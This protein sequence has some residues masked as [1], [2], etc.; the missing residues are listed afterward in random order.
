MDNF[1]R[2]LT[3]DIDGLVFQPPDPYTAGRFNDL[4]KWKPPE[5]S[6]VDFKLCITKVM[7]KGCPPVHVGFLYV[8]GHAQSYA[9]MPVTK[10]LQKY[11]NKIIECRFN[12]QTTNWEFVRERTDKSHPNAFHTAESVCRTIRFPVTKDYLLHFIANHG[13][14]VQEELERTARK[15]ELEREKQRQE[16]N[17]T[18]TFA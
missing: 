1:S 12:L 18:S 3:H 2:D 8:L 13:Y 14:G 10:A 15:K 17:S 5:H 16:R 6:T 9:K 7:Q 4:M 11:D